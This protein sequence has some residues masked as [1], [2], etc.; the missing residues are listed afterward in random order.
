MVGKWAE[1]KIQ[2]GVLRRLDLEAAALD[3]RLRN[4]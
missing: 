1:R 2:P 4:S 3:D